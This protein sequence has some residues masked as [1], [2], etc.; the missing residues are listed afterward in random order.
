MNLT[1]PKLA[2]E[3]LLFCLYQ[4]Q[5]F[6]GAQNFRFVIS[7]EAEGSAPNEQLLLG[8][9]KPQVPPLRFASVGMTSL[10]LTVHSVLDLPKASQVLGM[11]N[12]KFWTPA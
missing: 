9:N 6:M 2:F 8:V 5:R 10:W 3:A 1:C 12:P 11:T 4:Q 7:S